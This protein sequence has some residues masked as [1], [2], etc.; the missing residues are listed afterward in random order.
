MQLVR[1]L[2]D[3]NGAA[4]RPAGR[5]RRR[6]QANYPGAIVQVTEYGG[7]VVFGQA[8]Q[9]Q[10]GNAAASDPGASANYS[11]TALAADDAGLNATTGRSATPIMSVA[12]TDAGGGNASQRVSINY[13]REHNERY[14][15]ERRE[16]RA[17]DVRETAFRAALR[18]PDGGDAEEATSFRRMCWMGVPPRCRPDSWRLLAGYMPSVA[19]RRKKELSRKRDEYCD[20]V[21]RYYNPHV[22]GSTR[23]PEQEIAMRHQIQIDVPRTL[24]DYPLFK[25]KTLKATMERVLF[26]WAIRHPVS[27]YVQGINDLTTPFFAVFLSEHVDVDRILAAPPHECEEEFV[28]LSADDLLAVEADVYWCL[29]ALLRHVQDNFTYGQ[30]GIQE[31]VMRMKEIVTKVDAE[32][33]A[34]L[35]DLGIEF[36]QFAFRWMNCLLVREL[37]LQLAIRLWD[38][39]LAEGANYPELHV[40]VCAAFLLHWR[41]QLLEMDFADA[42]IFLQSVNKRHIFVRDLEAWISHAYLLRYTSV[43]PPS[44]PADHP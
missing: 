43:H 37:P 28:G 22:Q 3:T 32:F 41:P 44:T 15:S 40:Y 19:T 21:A 16:L 17:D 2:V 12:S 39:Y 24:G 42:M 11:A 1:H 25:T 8:Q 34:Y 13:K 26:V 4:E 7:I 20:Y 27:G 9:Q 10:P 31:M 35:D 18:L 29:T 38:T 14:D 30:I 6:R 23:I 33:V 36:L 5:R